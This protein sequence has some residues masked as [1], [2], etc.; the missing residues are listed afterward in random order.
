[1]KNRKVNM[2]LI[3]GLILIS[4]LGQSCRVYQST[5]ISLDDAIHSKT[6]QFKKV[7]TTEKET[8]HF[9]RI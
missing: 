4:F 7:R 6:S 5:T 2:R 9:R 1:M 3:S 8:Y